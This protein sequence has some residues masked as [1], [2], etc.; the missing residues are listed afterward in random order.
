MKVVALLLAAATATAC[1]VGPNFK[2]PVVLLPDTFRGDGAATENAAKT[3]ALGDQAWWDVFQD[4]RL[5]ELIGTALRQN[6]DLRIAAARIVEAQAQFRI[7]RADQFPTVDAHGSATRSRAAR[8]VVPFALD[9]YELSDFR[10]AV[11]ATWEVDFWGKY[12]RATEAARAALVATE[13]GR[14]AV[15]TSLIT[16][17]A[18]AYFEMQS[19]DVQREIA[20]RALASRREALRLTEIAARGGA[21][22]FLDV[23]GAEQLVFTAAG[24]IADL[25]RQIAQQEND[26]SVLLGLNPAAVPRGNSLAQQ[27]RLPEVPAGLP[28]ALLDRRPDINEAEQR[29]I[30]SNANIGMAKAAF[31]PQLTLTGNGGAESSALSDLLSQPAGLWSI[32]AA[33]SQPIFNA[34]R[35]RSRVAVASAQTQEA[36]L[37]YQRTVQ[38]SLREVSDALVAYRQGHLFREQQQ[39][40]DRSAA[41]ARRLAEIRYRGGATS[42]LEVLD[43]ETRAFSAQLGL[44]QAEVNERLALVQIYRALGGGW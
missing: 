23:R 29:L 27:V 20:T 44:A 6:F 36:A 3:I 37:V 32:G 28:S 16:Q 9:P 22:S 12:R 26:I 43:S 38:Q 42:F 1:T 15:T 39:L 11:A 5:R 8:S 2:R 33:L 18:G 14:R 40:L 41:D 24:T 17:V 25:D 7:T 10:L 35:T 19:L 21:V 34:G 4:D 13:W 31:F 30:A